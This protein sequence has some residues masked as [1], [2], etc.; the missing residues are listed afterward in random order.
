MRRERVELMASNLP[1]W[2]SHEDAILIEMYGQGYKIEEIAER[3]P[4]RAVG[5]VDVRRSQLVRAGVLQRRDRSMWQDK[6]IRE[7][8]LAGKTDREI[9]A[10]LNCTGANVCRRRKVLGLARQVPKVQQVAKAQKV[11][12][13]KDDDQC[14]I[15]MRRSD[16]VTETDG[17]LSRTVWAE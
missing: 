1:A 9:G 4:G 11:K 5:A 14:K 3:L 13:P 6:K 7:M 2:T 17:V 12:V 15:K 8:F 10:V 16:W